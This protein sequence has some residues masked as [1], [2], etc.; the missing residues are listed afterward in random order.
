[1]ECGIVEGEVYICLKFSIKT[2]A[3][4]NSRERTHRH[5]PE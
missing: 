5:S 2:R 4:E 1:M 3:L